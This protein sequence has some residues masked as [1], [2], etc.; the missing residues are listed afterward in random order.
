MVGASLNVGH[1]SEPHSTDSGKRH[2]K[3]VIE[4]EVLKKVAIK[5]AMVINFK[6]MS[7]SRRREG[8]E[9]NEM[10]L[11]SVTLSLPQANC[12]DW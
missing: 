2:Q 4:L 11:R 7:F 10:A 6:S 8:I 9:L 1:G 5:I 3:Q 12:L